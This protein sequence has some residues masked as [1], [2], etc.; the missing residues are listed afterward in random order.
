METHFYIDL[1]KSKI[2]QIQLAQNNS[3][4]RVIIKAHKS[5]GLSMT[6]I[7]K[8]LDWLPFEA[9]IE[10]KMIVLANTSYQ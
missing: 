10:F 1:P 8:N 4:A 2:I 5:D 3:A 9:R 6:I 7:K